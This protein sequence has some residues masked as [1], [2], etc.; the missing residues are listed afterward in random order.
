MEIGMYETARWAGIHRARF[1][2]AFR[3]LNDHA[4]AE[5]AKSHAIL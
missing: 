5:Q 4:A 3:M 2:N 1:E